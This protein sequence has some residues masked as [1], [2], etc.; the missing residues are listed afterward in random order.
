MIEILTGTYQVIDP[1]CGR[2]PA[3]IELDMGCGKGRLALELARRYPDRL[4]LGSDVM[5]GRLRRLDRKVTNRGL[6]NLVLLRADNLDLASYLLPHACI[7][8]IHLLCPDPWPKERHR[9]KRLVT[10]DFVGRLAR[11]LKP[12][13]VLHLSTDHLPYLADWRRIL[14][15]YPSFCEDSQAIADIADIQTEFEMQWRAAGKDVPHLA[16]R[17]E[18]QTQA[19]ST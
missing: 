17:F 19:S 12:G 11:L 16:F 10:T 4:V 1:T 8:R 3:A 7:D 6:A 5:L 9:I 14:A 18:P 13:G 2:T 15:A